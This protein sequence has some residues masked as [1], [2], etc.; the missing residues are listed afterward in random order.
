MDT[1]CH[2]GLERFS[3]EGLL[4]SS[5]GTPAVIWLTG[6]SG[7]GKTTLGEIVH[8]RIKALQFPAHHLDGDRIRAQNPHIGFTRHE[9][10][11]HIQNVAR[12]ASH[13]ERDGAFVIVSL[14]SPYREARA[15]ARDLCVNFVEVFV[16]TPL[17]E[18]AR[19]D[20][21]GLYKRAIAGEIRDFTGI[22]A[23]YEA[24]IHPNLSISTMGVSPEFCAEVI[25]DYLRRYL[26]GANTFSASTITV[27]PAPANAS[28]TIIGSTPMMTDM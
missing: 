21:K 22:S 1:D 14:I 18:C 20:V 16:S 3:H 9:R 8:R 2:Y 12:L 19:R 7:S 28:A 25:L 13:L 24:P 15:Y 6:L 23:P 26:S 17:L 4:P 27:P 11:E 10:M 5:K